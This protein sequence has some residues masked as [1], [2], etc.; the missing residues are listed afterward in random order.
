MR[1]HPSLFYRCKKNASMFSV[2]EVNRCFTLARIIVV[3]VCSK[4]AGTLN[5]H[6]FNLSREIIS[7][8]GVHAKLCFPSALC[9]L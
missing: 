3:C 7:S 2:H 9:H 1:G 4:T 8:N 5:N 6:Y